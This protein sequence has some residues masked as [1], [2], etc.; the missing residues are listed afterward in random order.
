[1]EED[2]THIHDKDR[3]VKRC[4][5]FY[6]ELYKS[7]RA[8]ADQDS[9]DDRTTT[10]SIDAPSILQSEVEA[11]MATSSSC[12]CLKLLNC[13]ISK[14]LGQYGLHSRRSFLIFKIFDRKEFANSLVN[15]S[16]LLSVGKGFVSTRP[17]MLLTRSNS[18]LV[19]LP[20]SDILLFS[21]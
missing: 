4:V 21:S 14:L 12:I 7:R 17:V 10:S 1:M 18:F 6:E 9:R 3:I 15:V 8:S 16:S 19:S 2:G 5:E 13:G 11:L 20:H